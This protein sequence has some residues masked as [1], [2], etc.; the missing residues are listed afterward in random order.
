MIKTTTS[1]DYGHDSV[2]RTNAPG[3]AAPTDRGAV[4]GG[5][6]RR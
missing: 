3:L 5:K 4:M 1:E 2:A 6:T